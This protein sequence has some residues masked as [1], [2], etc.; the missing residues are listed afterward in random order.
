MYKSCIMSHKRTQSLKIPQR[1]VSTSGNPPSQRLPLLNMTS[2]SPI[3]SNFSSLSE[4]MGM[5]SDMYMDSCISPIHHSH[6]S[7]SQ[8]TPVV[9]DILCPLPQRKSLPVHIE[10]PFTEEDLFR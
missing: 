4:R 3:T 2:C 8:E 1:P 9:G 10:K 6:P 7:S 5:Y